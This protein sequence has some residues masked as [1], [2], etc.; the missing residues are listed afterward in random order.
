MDS[1]FNSSVYAFKLTIVLWTQTNLDHS[2]HH[3]QICNRKTPVPSHSMQVVVFLFTYEYCL[4]HITIQGRCKSTLFIH[5][6]YHYWSMVP[7]I[8][9]I[10][11]ELLSG[12]WSWSVMCEDFTQVW[13]CTWKLRVSTNILIAK[14]YILSLTGTQVRDITYIHVTIKY[15]DNMV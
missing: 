9:V 1:S 12:V 4:L 11:S 3:Q 2:S 6:A 8:L 14:Y 15:K 5:S 7:L 13:S 10:S